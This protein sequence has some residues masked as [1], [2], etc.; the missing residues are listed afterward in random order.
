M[1]FSYTHAD[2]TYSVVT[3]KDGSILEIRRGDRTFP[4]DNK[5]DQQTWPSLDAWKA[6]W[7]A[8][9]TPVVPPPPSVAET[10][11]ARFC[12]GKHSNVTCGPTEQEVSAYNTLLQKNRERLAFYT[13]KAEDIRGACVYEIQYRRMNIAYYIREIA[14]HEKFLRGEHTYPPEFK[15]SN[16]Y[17]HHE[18]GLHPV[19]HNRHDNR[20]IIRVHKKGNFTPE[21]LGITADSKFFARD[22]YED[23]FVP[24]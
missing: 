3:L 4:A 16:L 24:L 17:V 18:G 15:H 1:K 6:T 21:K 9:A 7:P 8:D 23:V 2:K 10:I 20:V 11:I 22:K 19:Y 14:Q 5:A 13:Q 12:A